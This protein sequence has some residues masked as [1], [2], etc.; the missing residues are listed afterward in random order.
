[1]EFKDLEWRSWH[2]GISSTTDFDNGFRLSI[3]AGSGK[4]CTPRTM[5][6]SPDEFSTFEVAVFNPQGGWSTQDFIETDD[7]VAGWQSREN[8]NELIKKINK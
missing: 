2:D 1:M 4:Y 6:D 3:V 5:G 7:M 8:I